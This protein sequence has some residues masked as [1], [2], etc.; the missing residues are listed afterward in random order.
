MLVQPCHAHYVSCHGPFRLKGCSRVL[1]SCCT[2]GF[3]K[4]VYIYFINMFLIDSIEVAFTSLSYPLALGH[5]AS[6]SI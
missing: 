5:N 1:K 2:R 6:M 4:W 3:L